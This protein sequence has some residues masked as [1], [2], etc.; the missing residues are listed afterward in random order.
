[1]QEAREKLAFLRQQ[2]Y[3]SAT[4]KARWGDDAARATVPTAHAP[5]VPLPSASDTSLPGLIELDAD[6][7]PA[8]LKSLLS[9][10]PNSSLKKLLAAETGRTRKTQRPPLIAALYREMKLRKL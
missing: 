2:L 5:G 7:S 4:W 9:N 3:N 6:A 1:L 10:L 8:R